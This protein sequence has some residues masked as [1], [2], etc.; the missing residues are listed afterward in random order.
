MKASS[1]AG[2]INYLDGR[3]KILKREFRRIL[4]IVINEVGYSLLFNVNLP[5]T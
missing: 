4:K 5:N 1:N 2:Y 3:R